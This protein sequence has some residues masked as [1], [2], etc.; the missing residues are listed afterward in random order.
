M[1]RFVSGCTG[2][3]GDRRPARGDVGE[4]EYAMLETTFLL[5]WLVLQAT[6]M[7]TGDVEVVLRLGE[8]VRSSGQAVRTKLYHSRI[9]A[10]FD[11]PDGIWYEL[12]PI[13]FSFVDH[14]HMS[15]VPA[16]RVRVREQRVNTT[17]YA[18]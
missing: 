1:S 18:M 13:Y 15:T 7:V 5:C 8:R 2:G 11:T 16:S 14:Y 6:Q 9:F 3:V 12:I 4:S 17:R 10:L